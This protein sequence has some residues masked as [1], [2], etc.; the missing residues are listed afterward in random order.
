MIGLT[1]ITAILFSANVIL[2]T[3]QLAMIG[4]QYFGDGTGIAYFN[5]GSTEEFEHSLTADEGYYYEESTAFYLDA[6]P[7]VGNN[8]GSVVCGDD[9]STLERARQAAAVTN[10]SS[11][12]MSSSSPPS[13]NNSILG[14]GN[15]TTTT[16]I[17][18]ASL[19]SDKSRAVD[20]SPIVHIK[21]N[22][23]VTWLNQDTTSHWL[24]SL[25]TS[26]S[27]GLPS[28]TFINIFIP[29]NGGTYSCA[30]TEPGGYHYALGS[31]IKGAVI[32][33]EEEEEDTNT[34]TGQEQQP[35]LP[36]SPFSQE[37]Q[38]Q[39]EEPLTDG[40]EQ[41]PGDGISIMPGSS[42]LTDTAFQPNPFQARIGDR[43]TWVNDD[44]QPHTVTS[45]E[46]ANPD[47]KFDSGIMAPAADFEHTFTEA[48]EYP[49]F[50]LL[51]PNMVGTVIVR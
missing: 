49:Y 47:G 4:Q 18:S 29:P 11:G 21:V 41:D 44:S 26:F 31:D 2:G 24:T 12:T 51:H 40:Q 9:I 22:D 43:V 8:T 7:G 50:C 39:R 3:T 5:D 17:R 1:I 16:I 36:S 48:G 30:F 10:S 19:L 38:S 20:P 14:S 35:P 27:G 28:A 42:S 46:N 34:G 32:V 15:I 33:E 25:P 37:P 45:G 13:D 6:V 23:I